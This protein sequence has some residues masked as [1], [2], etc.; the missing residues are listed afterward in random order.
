MLL[1]ILALSISFFLVWE[2]GTTSSNSVTQINWQWEEVLISV[3][4]LLA[5]TIFHFLIVVKQRSVAKKILSAQSYS[6][7]H[8]IQHHLDKQELKSK[9]QDLQ[10]KQETLEYLIKLPISELKNSI[11]EVILCAASVMQ[12]NRV[13]VW[14]YE[15]K[16]KT[17]RLSCL[18]FYTLSTHVFFEE[19]D[20]TSIQFPHYFNA[21]KAHSHLEVFSDRELKQELVSYLS[22]SLVLSKLDIPILFEGK[23]IGL[24]TCEETKKN[25]EWK[26]ED[27]YF[28]QTLANIIC[29]ILERVNRKRTE[30]ALE[31][32][33]KR[34]HFM[35]EKSID[36]IISVNDQ[37]SITSW[38]IG[39][40]QLF[41]YA[42]SEVLSKPLHI[43][44]KEEV[45]LKE[46]SFKSKDLKAEHRNGHLFP[47][48][49]S[50]TRWKSENE[51]FDTFLIRDI[52]ER[53]EY[54]K[55]LLNAIK[56]SNAANQA[57]NELLVKISHELRTPLHIILGFT[58]CLLMGTEGPFNSIQ[59]INL[60]KIESSSLHLLK[61]IND[62]LN[63]VKIE[64]NRIQLEIASEDIIKTIH[65]CIEEIQP[66]ADKKNLPIYFSIHQLQQ[67]TVDMDKLRI[68]QVLLN[69]LDNAVKFTE[70]GF[71][72]IKLLNQHKGLEISI[73]DTG[74]GLT[75]NEMT[76]IFKTFSQADSSL[77]RKY[78]GT[79]LGL[80]I[81]KKII[82][83]HGG[84]MRA[85]SEKGKGSTFIFSLPKSQA[86]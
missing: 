13:G 2:G 36:A 17:D 67:L 78:G 64:A 15:S 7:L 71:I 44:F 33:E 86:Y 24:L 1:V 46:G 22:S 4:I 10:K 40:E 16:E 77:T 38:N 56:E 75:P 32:S 8:K 12:V 41:G 65:S 31:E 84:S 66:L 55:S 74:I 82:D 5:L 35:T 29:L 49:I 76:K 19:P 69:L 30:K 73:T 3:L 34:L 60:K 72:E 58:K 25:K 70:T 59:E 52:T 39:S 68:K 42:A 45:K 79:G 9:Q 26:Q 27:L 62:L 28:G 85:E 80:A 14:L 54:E 21:L 81:S 53:K 20:L 83:L 37:G 50:H 11:Q 18:S 63:L 61:L 43:V 57:K 23:L 51:Y 47:I 48:E 6:N